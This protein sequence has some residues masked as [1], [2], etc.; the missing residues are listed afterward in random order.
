MNLTIPNLTNADWRL[1]D[2]SRDR[3]L[4][5][6]NEFVYVGPNDFESNG[7]GSTTESADDDTDDEEEIFDIPAF[8]LHGNN[9]EI[10]VSDD[11]EDVYE[12]PVRNGDVNNN[13]DDDLLM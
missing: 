3:L 12:P 6:V 8:I 11:E 13:D 10:D 4:T 9:V 2:D 1:I 7:S 5:N